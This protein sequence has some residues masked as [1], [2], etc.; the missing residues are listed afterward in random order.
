ML[1]SDYDETLNLEWRGIPIK[2]TLV[3][4]HFN[5]GF[6]HIELRADR[7]LPMTETGYR[8][9]FMQAERFDEYDGLKD[10]VTRW[11]NMASNS[12]DWARIQENYAQPSLFD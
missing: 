7:P 4:E 6:H 5:S 2:V 10:F 3:K 11:L 9:H 12:R 8:S 1:E